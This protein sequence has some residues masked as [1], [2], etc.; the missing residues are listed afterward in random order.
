MQAPL[1]LAAEPETVKINGRDVTFLVVARI[2]RIAEKVR[3]FLVRGRAGDAFDLY[4]YDKTKIA[5]GYCARL[6]GLVAT[7]FAEDP[8][9]PEDEAL[10]ER[11]D[12]MLT[13]LGPKMARSSPDH[14]GAEH[15]AG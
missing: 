6:Y 14:Q 1:L 4:Y 8:D 12:A 2:E 3:A 15:R 11:F 13:E 7:K 10:P 9:V 5:K